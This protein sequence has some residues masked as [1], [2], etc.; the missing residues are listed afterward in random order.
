MVIT[1][2]IM[3][4]SLVFSAASAGVH[5]DVKAETGNKTSV[6]AKCSLEEIK[7][8]TSDV[9]EEHYIWLKVSLSYSG[10]NKKLAKELSKRSWKIRDLIT[11]MVHSKLNKE[12]NDAAKK[13][14]LKGEIKEAV[15][16]LLKAG[17]IEDVTFDKFVIS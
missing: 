6:P 3:A 14:K 4:L 10:D 5:A 13:E 17:E 11:E 9:E 15:N 2:I 16:S 12:M 7:S 8:V 1:R